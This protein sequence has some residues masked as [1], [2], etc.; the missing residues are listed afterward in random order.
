MMLALIAPLQ[1]D[2][3]Q[4][5]SAVTDGTLKSSVATMIFPQRNGARMADVHGPA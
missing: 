1:I 5:L 2:P 3:I 4:S